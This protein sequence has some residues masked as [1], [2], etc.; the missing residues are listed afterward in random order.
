MRIDDVFAFLD[1]AGKVLRIPILVVFFGFLPFIYVTKIYL[2]RRAM[3]P[4]VRELLTAARRGDVPAMRKALAGGAGVDV[5]DAEDGRTALMRAAAFGREEASSALLAVGADPRRTD[6]QGTTALHLAAGNGHV[7]VVRLLLRAGAAVDPVG[8]PWKETPLCAALRGRGETRPR[9]GIPSPADAPSGDRFE[10]V[11]AALVDAHANANFACAGNS[12][13]L[14]EA[15]GWSEAGLVRELLRGHADPNATDPRSPEP[16]L[17]IAADT[18][19]GPEP[20]IVALLLGAGARP[21]QT[22][23]SGRTAQATATEA[24]SRD[25]RDE[26][27]RVHEAVLAA[28]ANPGGRP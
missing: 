28:L 22:G 27:R 8:G 1:R 6:V 21:G 5:P 2:P 18:C 4:A 10:S 3:S 16:P 26:C 17:V 12:R 20:E 13:P 25:R 23:R 7:D 14:S 24:L 9:P 11:V 19:V 15:T